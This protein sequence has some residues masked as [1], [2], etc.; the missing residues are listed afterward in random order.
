MATTIT[1]DG[2][3][4]AS[5]SKAVDNVDKKSAANLQAVAIRALN[6]TTYL[7]TT[8]DSV[9]AAPVITTTAT[10]AFSGETNLGALTTGMLKISVSAG[11]ATPSTATEGTDYYKPGGTDVAVAD[12]GTGASTAAAARTNLGV[13]NTFSWPLTFTASQSITADGQQV[14]EQTYGR[15]WG[16]NW[17][18]ANG[19]VSINASSQ[20]S[21]VFTSGSSDYIN[22]T[23]DGCALLTQIT[24]KMLPVR[25]GQVLNLY[26]TAKIANEAAFAAGDTC[27]LM[28]GFRGTHINSASTGWHVAGL[29]LN[30][31]TRWVE[32]IQTRYDVSTKL[33][34]NTPGAS[35][36][37]TGTEFK[38][39]LDSDFV[40]RS[41][42][43]AIGDSTWIS[44]GSTVH[45][46]NQFTPVGIFL[47]IS[48]TGT[49]TSTT[50]LIYGVTIELTE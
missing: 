46:T 2:T 11:T 43:R 4:S 45:N 30:S 14:T 23:E 33:N 13:D 35:F 7:K 39:Q 49:V 42:Y 31:T 40:F 29:E 48:H 41:W 47:F 28:G 10:S 15:Y 16:A 19:T 6:N 5:A 25:A 9:A 21:N 26:F 36:F 34:Q 24:P 22:G 8:S 18:A 3:Y 1:G 44:L 32:E 27:R 20:F 50:A 38:V 12:G 17:S 37:S